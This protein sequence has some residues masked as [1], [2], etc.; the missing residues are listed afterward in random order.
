[1][2]EDNPKKPFQIN[3][4]KVEPD[5]VKRL[6]ELLEEAKKGQIKEL[7]CIYINHE[8]KNYMVYVGDCGDVNKMLGCIEVAKQEFFYRYILPNRKTE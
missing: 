4:K 5:I 6:E 1:M 8:L 3:L 2:K 7:A